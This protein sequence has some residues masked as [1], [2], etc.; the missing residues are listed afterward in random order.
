M[1]F[2]MRFR[3]MVGRILFRIRFLGILYEAD[4][5]NLQS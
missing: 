4:L 5:Y 3:R 2:V 1:P